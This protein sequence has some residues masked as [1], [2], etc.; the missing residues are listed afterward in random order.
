ML[1]NS[2]LKVAPTLLIKLAKDK[3]SAVE[4]ERGRARGMCALSCLTACSVAEAKKAR[5]R[6]CLF[7]WTEALPVLNVEIGSRPK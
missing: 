1:R 6:K 4:Q 3:Q 2:V 7:R 5:Q